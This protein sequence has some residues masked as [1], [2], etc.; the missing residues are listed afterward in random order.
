MGTFLRC[1]EVAAGDLGEASAHKVADGVFGLHAGF[2]GVFEAHGGAYAEGAELRL[3]IGGRKSL[4]KDLKPREKMGSK[5]SW[6]L[7]RSWG[8]DLR[9]RCSR[10]S[11]PGT[12]D[13][14]KQWKNQIAATKALKVFQSLRRL[15]FLTVI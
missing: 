12:D 1:G 14:S 2:A 7:A 8:I 5:V 3:E 13:G 15:P 6:K 11:R 4:G 9:R 10:G